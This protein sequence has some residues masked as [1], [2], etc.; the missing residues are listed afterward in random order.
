MNAVLLSIHTYW[1]Q[2]F[3]LFVGVLQNI[4]EVCRAYLWSGTANDDKGGHAKWSDVHR[5]KKDGGLGLR[6]IPKWNIASIGK[7]VCISGLIRMI[8]G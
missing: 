3:L 6:Q 2:L 4:N 1:A 8:Y 5:P 7:L